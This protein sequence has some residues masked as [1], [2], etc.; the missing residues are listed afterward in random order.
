MATLLLEPNLLAPEF[1]LRPIQVKEQRME[2]VT[3]KATMRVAEEARVL[4]VA[5]AWAGRETVK[6][7]VAAVE[8]KSHYWN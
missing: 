1:A 3:T 7:A 5:T 8:P 2:V 6:A 4:E